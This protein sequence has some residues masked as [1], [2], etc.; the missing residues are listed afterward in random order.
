MATVI[1][2]GRVAAFPLVIALVF[3]NA[4]GLDLVAPH[5]MVATRLASPK[6]RAVFP[7]AQMQ[8]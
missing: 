8:D 1:F 5:L 6:R 2:R 7:A 4:I 3:A